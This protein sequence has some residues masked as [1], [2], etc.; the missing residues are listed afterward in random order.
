MDSNLRAGLVELI[1]TFVYVFI[2]AGTVCAYYLTG[3]P[4][5]NVT[6]FALAAGLTLAVLLTASWPVSPGCFNPA[7]AIMLYVFKRL[8]NRRL[9]ALIVLQ[10]LGAALA[11]LA[12][13][14]TFREDVL[15]SAQMGV[16]R[17]QDSL[18]LDGRVTIGGLFAGVCVEMLLTALVVVALFATLLDPRGPKM[19]GVAVGLAQTAAVL[20]GFRLT[21]GAANPARWFGPLVWEMTLPNWQNLHPLADHAVYWA[22]PILGA[23]LG[24]F[25]YG[26]LILPADRRKNEAG[27]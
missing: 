8:D 16:T 12:L 9:L 20:F 7:I 2:S 23:L 11:G 6:A 10:L 19:G 13:R 14:L 5:L 18:L 27:G 15:Y 22:G 1:G 21:G 4:D 24:G 25:A 26:W 3:S 17:L